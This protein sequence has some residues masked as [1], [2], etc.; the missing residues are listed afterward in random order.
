MIY[1]FLLLSF[2]LVCYGISNM[3]VYS[4]GP[5]HIF[6]KWRAFTEKIHPMVGELFSCMMC[7]PF[8]VGLI[9]SAIDLFIFGGLLTP[10]NILLFNHPIGISK[11][12]TVLFLDGSLSSGTTWVLHNIEE[13]FESNSKYE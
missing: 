2:I 9:I 7:F 3:I 8:W 5:F 12:I 11:I 10:F 4:N 6:S 13:Y 1:I